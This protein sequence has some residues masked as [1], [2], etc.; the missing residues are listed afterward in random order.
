[1]AVI[2]IAFC[3]YWFSVLMTHHI[4]KRIFVQ[5]SM[6]LRWQCAISPTAQKNFI[7]TALVLL[8]N[9]S[10]ILALISANLLTSKLLL[11][12]HYLFRH[13]CVL[14]QG[15]EALPFALLTEKKASKS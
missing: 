4:V 14:F 1:M 15:I 13:Y 7:P 5:N 12:F 8:T 2:L 3:F 11:D 10:M 6:H 9:F